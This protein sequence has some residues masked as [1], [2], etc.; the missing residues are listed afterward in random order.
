MDIERDNALWLSAP[1][2]LLMPADPTKPPMVDRKA[3]TGPVTLIHM[4]RP[5]SPRRPQDR[6]RLVPPIHARPEGPCVDELASGMSTDARDI[7]LSKT[8]SRRRRQLPLRHPVA[9][10]AWS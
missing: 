10:L 2:P 4:G 8:S 6:R 3:G 5:A 7:G 1:R 9:G